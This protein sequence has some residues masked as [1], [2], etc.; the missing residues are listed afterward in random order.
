MQEVIMN[1]EN[2][3]SY[4]CTHSTIDFTDMKHRK[5]VKDI[6]AMDEMP[7]TKTI[8]EQDCQHCPDYK[9]RF[10]EYPLTINGI[11]YSKFDRYN[12]DK[13]GFV[14]IRPCDEKYEGKTY[15][16]LLVGD[17]PLSPT[18]SLN[19]NTN[20]LT[21]GLMTNPAIFVF[22]T[23]EIVYGCE[24]WWQKITSPDDMKDIT[25][26]IIDSQWYVAMMKA[27]PDTDEITSK[28]DKTL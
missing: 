5:C 1:A 17:M 22:K 10:I 15:L 26:D 21:V 4:H 12:L 23:K 9:S 24:S 14:A 3:R 6:K 2:K 28:G 20:R 18:V 8:T 13:P 7:N 19:V 16:G 25:D 27:M 11:D